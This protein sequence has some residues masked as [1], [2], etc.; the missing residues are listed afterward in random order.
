MLPVEKIMKVAARS[1]FFLVCIG[2]AI[3]WANQSG[4]ANQANQTVT[5]WRYMTAS[6]KFRGFSEADLTREIQDR[7]DKGW[8][9]VETVPVQEQGHT[10]MMLTIWRR[11]Q[12]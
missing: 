5:K 7:I 10:M 1:L 9:L 11:P 3:A 6:L 12:D 2:A 8:E 4:T